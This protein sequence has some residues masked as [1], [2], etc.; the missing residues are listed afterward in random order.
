MGTGISRTLCIWRNEYAKGRKSGSCSLLLDSLDSRTY[1]VLVGR[2]GLF[3]EVEGVGAGVV[4]IGVKRSSEVL[5]DASL[6]VDS[7]VLNHLRREL[8]E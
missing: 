6:R 3:E 2:D 5:W 7:G 4:E 1:L 8:L